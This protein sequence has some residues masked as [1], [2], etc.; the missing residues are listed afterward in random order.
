MLNDSRL[1]CFLLVTF[2]CA[3][4]AS[5]QQVSPQ[6][7]AATGK[8]DLDVVVSPKSG[9]PVADLQQSDFIPSRQ[10]PPGYHRGRLGN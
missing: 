3:A 5:A 2:L 10:R 8:I 7:R 6:A 1:A 4:A 9:P